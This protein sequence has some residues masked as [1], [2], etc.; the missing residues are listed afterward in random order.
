L[1]VALGN[2]GIDH[3]EQ[4]AYV[5]ALDYLTQQLAIA[6][7]LGDRR[8]AS[9]AV[10]YIGNVYEAVGRYDDA[11][12][13]FSKQLAIAAEL[14]DRRVAAIAL[15][16]IARVRAA[17]G[18]DRE[19]EELY[20]RGLTVL[21]ALD[22]PHYVCEMRYRLADLYARR[23][24]FAEARASAAAALADATRVKRTAIQFAAEL[25]DVHARLHLG[26]ISPASKNCSGDIR[27]QDTGRRPS[28][29]GG[30]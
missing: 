20:T 3:E 4:G 29:N 11:L 17:Q 21:S 30:V 1:A 13:C 18:A 19:A 14:D 25:L 16:N 7:D 27:T 6:E 22:L 26:E 23:G 15:G 24:R 9:H 28:M 8:S 5:R 2:I 10:W 12:A